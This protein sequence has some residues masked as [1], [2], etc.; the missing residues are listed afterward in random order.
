[1]PD[2]QVL[3]AYSQNLLYIQ[4]LTFDLLY[5]PALVA[6]LGLETWRPR[7]QGAQLKALQGARLPEFEHEFLAL[8]RVLD[9]MPDCMTDD[10]SPEVAL[11]DFRATVAKIQYWWRNRNQRPD[12]ESGRGRRRGCRGNGGVESTWQVWR[13]RQQD[14]EQWLWLLGVG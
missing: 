6:E 14:K 10:S 11:Q 13:K 12:G 3:D 1:M 4:S 9:S 5:P 7:V 2:W 8:K